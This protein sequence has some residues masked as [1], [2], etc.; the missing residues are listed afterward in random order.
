MRHIRAATAGRAVAAAGT[1]TFAAL[2]EDV[3]PN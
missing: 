1:V 3:L 2:P